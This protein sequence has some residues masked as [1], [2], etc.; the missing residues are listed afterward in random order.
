MKKLILSLLGAALVSPALADFVTVTADISTDTRWTRDIV[1]ILTR[2]I[3]VTDAATLTIEPGTIIRGINTTQ[4][5]INLEPGAL[6]IRRDAKIIAN[7]TPDDPIVFTSI[8]DTNV[9]GGSATVP[10]SFQNSL[11]TTLTAGVEYGTISYSTTPGGSAGSSAFNSHGLWGGLIVLGNA[12]VGQSTAP[13]SGLP[14]DGST[15]D[16]AP[17]DGVYDNHD[18]NFAD[19]GVDLGADGLPGGSDENEDSVVP[20]VGSDFIEG[21]DP[22]T[23]AGSGKDNF[24]VYGGTDDSDNSGTIAFVSIRYGGFEL[25]AANEINSFTTGGMGDS[26]VAEFIEC[27]FNQ[28]D[29]FEPFGGKYDTRFWFSFWNLDDAFDGDEGWRS[30]SQFWYGV[31]PNVSTY[32]TSGSGSGGSPI[33]W[34][35]AE[36]SSGDTLPTLTVELHNFTYL[37]AASGSTIDDGSDVELN[38]FYVEGRTNTLNVITGGD[39]S[40]TTIDADNWGL[41]NVSAADSG[42]N[43]DTATNV[44]DYGDLDFQV[45]DGINYRNGGV[46]DPR[47]LSGAT[48]A[49]VNGTDPTGP[50]SVTGAGYEGISRDNDFSFGWTH[51]SALGAGPSTNIAR[52]SL[53]IGVSGS[54]PTITWTAVA[55]QGGRDVLYVVERSLEGKVWTPI[56]GATTYSA[57][58]Q[59]VTDTGVTLTAGTQVQYR[60]YAL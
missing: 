52:P 20:G 5:E 19:G 45:I 24:G 8:D 26:T 3:Y 54:N 44:V 36:P 32:P 40:I 57:G 42:G 21:I 7:G 41:V 25:G 22:V 14:D 46:L 38:N 18:A 51:L 31:S 12:R 56:T 60:A 29:G 43:L 6:V 59:T 50:Q 33:E 53:T 11:G 4:S 55:G 49:I 27:T 13:G 17:V 39:P 10:T 34:D 35:G 58:S 15:V 28:D 1:Y 48:S 16:T 37:D 9:P 2:T 23:L 30:Y 47:L